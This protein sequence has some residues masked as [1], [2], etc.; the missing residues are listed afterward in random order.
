MESSGNGAQQPVVTVTKLKKPVD[1]Q[2][3]GTTGYYG[4]PSIPALRPTL[5]GTQVDP[6]MFVHPA[7]G[8]VRTTRAPSTRW[9][10]RTK[11]TNPLPA[12]TYK[13]WVQGDDS[14]NISLSGAQHDTGF[15]DAN[16][17]RQAIFDMTTTGITSVI[18]A[19]NFNINI[20]D[21]INPAYFSL[22]I[23]DANGNVVFNGV[24]SVEKWYVSQ[25]DLT[26]DNVIE[27]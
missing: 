8:D 26:C 11:L 13:V 19:D 3:A 24:D 27:G 16:Q 10:Y 1:E 5:N 15:L 21:N 17:Q 22:V 9:F 12:G 14:V 18:Y 2:L 23:V 6:A 4:F 25:T 7:G 20:G